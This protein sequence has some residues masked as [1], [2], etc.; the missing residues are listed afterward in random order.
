M[1][2]INRLL[3]KHRFEYRDHPIGGFVSVHLFV[4]NNVAERERG[5]TRD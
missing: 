1:K 5:M 2:D 4:C 3:S